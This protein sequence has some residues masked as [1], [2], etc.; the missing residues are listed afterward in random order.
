MNIIYT[1][2]ALAEMIKDLCDSLSG[3]NKKS[4]KLVYQRVP[5]SNQQPR[6]KK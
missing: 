3:S 4:S 2:K 1:F 5:V 6:L